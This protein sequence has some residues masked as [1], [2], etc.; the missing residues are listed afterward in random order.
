MPPVDFPV[1]FAAHYE[2][3]PGSLPRLRFGTE[4]LMRA[5]CVDLSGDARPIDTPVPSSALPPAETFGRLEPIAAP[6]VVRRRPRPVPGV[7][8]APLAIVLRSDYDVD[9]ATVTPQDRLLF[10]AQVGQDLCELHGQPNGG[11]DPTSYRLLATRDAREPDDPWE[12]D[13]VTGEPIAGG[14]RR[15][16]LRYLSDPFVGR[17]RAFHHG[18]AA[19]HLATIGGAW[20]AVNSARIDVVAGDAPTETNPDDA[21]ELRIAVAKADIHSVDLSYAPAE[22]GVEEFGL[23]HQLGATDQAALRSTIENGAHWMFS[24]RAPLQLVHAVRRPLLPP[25]VVTT[26]DVTWTASREVGSTGVTFSTTVEI[27]RRSTERLTLAARWVDLVDDLR[28]DGPEPRRGGAPLGR[29]LTP[30]DTQSPA[31]LRHRRPARRARRHPTP[32]GDDRPGGVQQL[33]RLLHR[34]AHRGDQPPTDRDRPPR[35][36]QGDR[37]GH[38]RRR[39][40]G[41]R[42]DR[43]RHRLRGGKIA[44]IRGGRFVDGD[45]V[46]VRYVPLPV[47]RTSDE[48]GL[49]PFEFV[50]LSTKA[51]PPPNVVDVV[52]AF[53]RQRTP[54]AG[55]RGRHPRRQR[56][57]HLPRPAVEV[58]R[59][60]RAARRARRTLPW[61]R[62]AA[63]C[64][65]RDPIVT[66][67]TTALDAAEFTRSAAVVD[68]PTGSTTSP[69]TTCIRRPQPA[70]VRRPRRRDAD[71][72]TVP[73]PRARP[74]PGRLRRRPAAQPHVTLD[75]IRLGVNRTV[76]SRAGPGTDD[77]TSR[78]PAR[79]TAG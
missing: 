63:T 31:A 57:A 17:L 58:Q 26:P 24:A 62:P 71:V 61:G 69:C 8:D 66:G 42:G 29:F 3:V 78:C 15:Q 1:Q 51:P 6:F 11:V 9:D 19:E 35:V 54:V 70:L 47:S 49:E 16:L 59:R 14:R 33:Q 32:R 20:P 65:G 10:P 30:R 2:V 46:T 67:T 53:A 28:A 25:Q 21:T 77:S 52:P 48:P 73:A 55:A 23:W 38:R 12:T 60:R 50:F 74:L 5:R 72:P 13:A 43:L 18:E 56:R 76:R 79:T 44:A 36:R 4:Y 75:P 64:V 27:E 37:V 22:G 45:E 34:G 40:R 7:G 39:H 68:R 41:E